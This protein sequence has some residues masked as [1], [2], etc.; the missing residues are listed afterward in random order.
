[1]TQTKKAYSNY[2]EIQLTPEAYGKSRKQQ[3]QICNEIL[4]EQLSL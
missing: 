1:M 2:F 4:L 3:N